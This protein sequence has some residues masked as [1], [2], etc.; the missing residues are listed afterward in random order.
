MKQ[1]YKS[2]QESYD[3]LV[4]CVK[5]YPNLIRLQSIGKTHEQREILMVTLTLNVAYADVKP[6]LLYTGTIHAREWIGNELGIEFIDYLLK[7]YQSNPQILKILTYNTLYMVPCL[8]P[9]GF[10]Y[11]RKHFSFWRKNRRNNGDG[12]FGVDLNRNFSVGWQKVT[13]TKSNVYGGSEPFSEPETRAIRDFVNTHDNITMALDYHSQGNVFFPAHKFNHEPEIEGSDLNNICANMNY[14]IHKTSGRK[15]GIHRGKPPTKLISGSGREFYYSKGILANVVEVGTRNIPDYMQNMSESIRENIP[16][17]LFALGEARNYS[18][19][20]PA[21]VKNFEISSFDSDSCHLSWQYESNNKLYFEIYRNQNNKKACNESSLIGVTCEKHFIDNNLRSGIPY[22]YNIRA[23]NKL[24][25]VKSP[26]APQVKVKTQ[27]EITEFSKT[28]F[29]LKTDVGYVAQK[30]IDTNPKHFGVSSFRVGVSEDRGIAYGVLRFSLQTLPKDAIILDARVSIYPLNRVGA[31]IEKYGEWS[32]SIIEQD[33]IND[34]KDFNQIHNANHQKTV[35]LSI[36]SEK[37]TQGI[38]SHWDF[39]QF[40][41]EYL[42]KEI[43]KGKVLFRLK[44]PTTLPVGRDSQ[45]MIFD[46]GYGNEGGGL[47]YRPVLD[48]K[49]TIPPQTITL[50]ANESFTVSKSS[51][52]DTKLI[53]GFDN[54]SEKIYGFISFDLSSLPNFEE[55][56]IK[57]A[58]IEIENITTVKK[59]FDLRYNLEFIDVDDDICYDDIKNRER[60]EFIGYEISGADLK[61]RKSHHMIFDHYSTLT[62]E[63][64]RRDKKDAKFILRPTSVLTKK[65]IVEWSKN[66]VKGAKLV[67]NYIKK[68]RLPPPTPTNVHINIENKLIKISWNG[69][70]SDDLGGYFVVRNRWHPP[71]NPFDGEKIYAGMDTYTFDSFGSTK[72]EKFY[73]VFSYDNVPNYSNPITIE[74]KNDTHK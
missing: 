21:R 1:Q 11:S 34:L 64:K 13:D 67:V 70:K 51:I 50:E 63:D 44:G 47:H 22:F 31:K 33:N 57:S 56:V 48:I 61:H 23:V 45:M 20:A 69:V 2:Y 38:W 59:D 39:N 46:I 14:Y 52:E 37:L 27:L 36:P 18:D 72:V 53:C 68:R 65:Q 16:A 28:I 42:Q 30:T 60:I 5:N 24:T 6:A 10:E 71:K 43:E 7:N 55:S 62:L 35:G 3:Y 29:P 40:E 9:D 17:L 41:K 32:L 49:Y 54:E 12:S 8:N 73:A 19:E 74:Y 25:N 15:Y 58:W 4:D 26:F 66:G